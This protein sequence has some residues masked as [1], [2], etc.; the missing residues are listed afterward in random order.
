MRGFGVPSWEWPCAPCFCGPVA[1]HGN[2]RSVCL[3]SQ[4]S[5][6]PS[7]SPERVLLANQLCAIHRLGCYDRAEPAYFDAEIACLVC[8]LP[9]GCAWPRAEQAGRRPFLR[10]R[11]DGQLPREERCAL[12]PNDEERA[13]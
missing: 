5:L 9:S 13:R 6:P 4:H 8:N 2:R 10:P 3:R 7:L 12:A 1:V 11:R